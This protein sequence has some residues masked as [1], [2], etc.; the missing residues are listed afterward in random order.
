MTLSFGIA[1]ALLACKT[2]TISPKPPACP[3]YSPDAYYNVQVLMEMPEF[4]PLITHLK[5]Q[6]RQ[7]RAIEAMR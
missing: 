7:C 2:P 1:F 3:E 4:R 6:A 5:M